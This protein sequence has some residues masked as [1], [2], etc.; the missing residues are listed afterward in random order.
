MREE[1]APPDGPPP[2]GSPPGLRS[3]GGAP[4]GRRRLLRGLLAGAGAATLGAS[5]AGCGAV[6]G[7][8]ADPNT[9][10]YWNLFSGGAGGLQRQMIAEAEERAGVRVED[11]VLAW[12]APY[13]T[14]LAMAAAGGRAP[15]VAVMHASRLAGHAPGGLLDPWDME[16]LAE[17][18]V[19]PEH[20]PPELWRQCRQGYAATYAIPLDTHPLVVFYDRDAMAA[21]DLLTAEGRLIDFES[22]EHFLD[23]AAELRRRNE[24]GLGPVFGHVSDPAQNWRLFWGLFGQT[25]ATFDLGGRRADVDRDAA[26]R[27]LRFMVDLVAPDCRTYNVETATSQFAGRKAPAVLCGE[28][29]LT[30]YAAVPGLP[31]DGAAFPVLFGRP[32]NFA[33]S[34]TFVLPHQSSPDPK[35]R[36]ATHRF[37][38][39]MLKSSLTWAEAGH[40]PAYRP[41]Q[42]SD[43]YRELT[44]QSH[45]AAAADRVFLDPPVWFTGAGSEF[46]TRMC[47]AMQS[48]MLGERPA[49]RAVDAMV[50]EIDVFLS[51]PTPVAG[52]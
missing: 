30:T 22:P 19:T 24:H 33:D 8:T 44:P 31:L 23:A 12:G 38:A 18:G 1:P 43:A 52:T 9:V 28:W 41:V 25:G 3:P 6:A 27:V 21:A 4:L 50:D 45:Y 16:L 42:E 5:A 17:L 36:R 15:D 49:A 37:V 2:G 46:Q 7:A 32:A 20:F 35:R 14:K 47:D 11:T 10:R 26:T 29:E 13:Y 48:A 51:R 34:H 40:I 39:E